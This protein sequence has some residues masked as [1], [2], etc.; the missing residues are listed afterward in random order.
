VFYV[1]LRNRTDEDD[2]E[3]IRVKARDRDHAREQ[4]RERLG[5]RFTLG[6]VWTSAEFR[7]IDPVWWRAI[8]KD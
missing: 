4:A 8:A 2:N 3:V 1:L 6:N 5:W 7:R